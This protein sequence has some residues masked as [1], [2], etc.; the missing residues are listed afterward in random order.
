MSWTD[1]QVAIVDVLEGVGAVTVKVPGEVNRSA[2][3]KVYGYVTPSVP[4]LPCVVLPPPGFETERGPGRRETTYAQAIDVFTSAESRVGSYEAIAIA[5]AIRDAF[6]QHLQLDGEAT[7]LE[8]PHWSGA[9]SGQIGDTPVIQYSGV[10]EILV[11]ED[12]TYSA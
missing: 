9:S 10:L 8:G 3:L 6:G 4:T 7:T 2:R 1:I 12:V 5:E 11:I